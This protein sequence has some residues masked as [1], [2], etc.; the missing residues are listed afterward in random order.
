MWY[1][2]QINDAYYMH[3]SP[4]HGHIFFLTSKSGCEILLISF[5]D[6]ADFKENWNHL[7]N[8][9]TEFE[10]WLACIFHMI[11]SSCPEHLT[12]HSIQS[13]ASLSLTKIWG[14]FFVGK[15]KAV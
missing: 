3:T 4:E 1:L 12:T 2:T 14:L 15:D 7:N 5:C 13:G 10:P 6:V 9:Q 11:V 8:H